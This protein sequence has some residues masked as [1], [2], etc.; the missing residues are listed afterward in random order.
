LVVEEK[1]VLPAQN[2]IKLFFF[3]IDEEKENKLERL[4]LEILS[5]HG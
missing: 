1:K 5:C 2:F 4:Y 3:V